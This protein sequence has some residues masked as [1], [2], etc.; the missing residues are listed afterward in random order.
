MANKQRKPQENGSVI[1]DPSGAFVCVWT[2][3]GHSI[4]MTP[5]LARMMAEQ[6]MGITENMVTPGDLAQ[7]IKSQKQLLQ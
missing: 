3:D 7:I 6:V 4:L 5:A 1:H 2:E